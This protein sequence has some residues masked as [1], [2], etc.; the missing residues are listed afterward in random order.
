MIISG[1]EEKNLI[2]IGVKIAGDFLHVEDIKN[3]V[4]YE[5]R[6]A[7]IGQLRIKRKLRSMVSG[8]S[9]FQLIISKWDMSQV[10]V[11]VKDANTPGL[12]SALKTV[13]DYFYTES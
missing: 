4:T 3:K 6:L 1:V 11:E 12:K 2:C 13:N 7:E 8:N 9:L 5:I 10:K